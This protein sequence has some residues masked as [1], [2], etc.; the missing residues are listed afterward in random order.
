MEE[1]SEELDPKTFTPVYLTGQDFFYGLGKAL[2]FNGKLGW[3][4][5]TAGGYV[6]LEIL[7][8]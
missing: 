2:Q 7:K 4:M 1:N 3:H 8:E 5:K 6:R